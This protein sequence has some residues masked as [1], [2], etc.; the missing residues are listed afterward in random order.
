MTEKS[1]Q[2]M[3]EEIEERQAVEEEEADEKKQRKEA[4]LINLKWSKIAVLICEQY[5]LHN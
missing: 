5:T 1:V 3:K 2:C 4:R